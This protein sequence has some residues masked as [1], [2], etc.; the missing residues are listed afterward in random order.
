[1]KMNY[2]HIYFVGIGGIGMSALA[3]YFHQLGWPVAG[4]DKTISPLTVALEKSGIQVHYEDLGDK[5]QPYLGSIDKTLIVWTPAVPPSLKELDFLREKNYSIKKRA[6]VLGEIS[7][8]FKT[9]AVAGTHGKTTTAS[10]LAHVLA[11]SHQGCNAFLGGISTNFNSN[12][13]IDNESS[14]MV[15]EADEFDRSFHQLSPFSSIITSIEADHLD[16]Y[17][18]SNTL[19][20]AFIEFGYLTHEEGRLIMSES[21]DIPSRCAQIKYGL[22]TGATVDYHGFN[23]RVENQKFVFDVE[24]PTDTYEGIILGLPGIHNVSNALAVIAMCESIGIPFSEIRPA[25]KS[26]KGVKRRFEKVAE[27]KSLVYIDDYAHHP[28]AIT[29][30]IESIRLMYENQLV[31]VVFQPHLYSRTRDFMD[32]FAIALS[33]ADRVFL[34]PIYPAREEPIIGITSAALAEKITV[35]T[36]V[37]TADDILTEIKKIKNG[38]LLTVGAGNIDRLVA[39]IGEYLNE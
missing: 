1:M 28:T 9:L 10:M 7:K 22:K 15:V 26:F 11:S 13:V 12:L 23:L 20:D 4:Y 8:D 39:P 32:E 16:I 25:L 33:L 6:V 38:V 21:V 30:L 29:R 18:D 2:S 3:R 34:L 37:V 31:T 35:P 27:T 14:W 5:I 36:K 24:T 19:K 17:H